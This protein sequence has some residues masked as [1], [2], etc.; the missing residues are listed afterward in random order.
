MID[1]E[2]G[3]GMFDDGDGIASPGKLANKPDHERGL[4]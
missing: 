4:A 3:M 1:L 2:L